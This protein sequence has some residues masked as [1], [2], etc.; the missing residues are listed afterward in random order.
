MHS[1]RCTVII[2][3]SLYRVSKKLL[4]VPV[5]SA[6]TTVHRDHLLLV[7]NAQWPHIQPLVSQGQMVSADLP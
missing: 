1:Y 4:F 7:S 5:V 6:M 2:A 3:C